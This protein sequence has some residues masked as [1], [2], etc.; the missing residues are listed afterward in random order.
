MS[1]Y[2]HK[3]PEYSRIHLTNK[4]ATSSLLDNFVRKTSIIAAIT[5]PG[6]RP[7]PPD[8][9]QMTSESVQGY[10]P[11]RRAPPPTQLQMTSE[12]V[13]LLPPPAART[14]HSRE[15]KPRPSIIMLAHTSLQ[16]Q[17]TKHRTR[18]TLNNTIIKA[19][20]SDRLKIATHSPTQFPAIP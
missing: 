18:S 3:K 11:D 15:L 9:V 6:H 12:C 10:P 7:R 14:A 20:K 1:I 17:T 16:Q 5:S 13:Q 2:K 8:R 19:V 4:M